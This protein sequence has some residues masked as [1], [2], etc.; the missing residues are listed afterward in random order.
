MN[1]VDIMNSALAIQVLPKTS[2]GK[3]EAHALV[4]K[5]IEAIERSGLPYT[6]CPFETV[7]E[8]PLD[9]LLALIGETHRAVLE[10]G[11]PGV[12]TYMKLFSSMDLASSEEKVA[13]Y[14]AKGH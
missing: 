10:A 8:G 13:K 7:V 3:D 1:T 2:G 4:D 9:Q 12:S 11:A 5:A 14:R 6:V